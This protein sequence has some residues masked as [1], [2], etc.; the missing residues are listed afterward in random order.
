MYDSIRTA[1]PVAD[2]ERW[3]S[4]E[5]PRPMLD[6]CPICGEPVYGETDGWEKDDAYEFG[7]DIVH[8]DCVLSYLKQ[9]GYKL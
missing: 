8:E 4:R 9:K 5:D 2:A 3:A 6:I 7:E 1:D